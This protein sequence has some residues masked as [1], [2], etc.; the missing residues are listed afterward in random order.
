MQLGPRDVCGLG[1]LL[2]SRTLL[3]KAQ[4]PTLQTLASRSFQR[5]KSMSLWGEQVLLIGTLSDPLEL[6]AQSS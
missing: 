6:L 5:Q 2:H 1:W 3:R 4:P